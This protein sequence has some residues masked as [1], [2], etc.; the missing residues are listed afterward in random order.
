LTINFL[1]LVMIR[2][3]FVVWFL[4]I[5]VTILAD[6]LEET[7]AVLT[8]P[9]HLSSVVVGERLAAG[10]DSALSIGD[11]TN[12]MMGSSIIVNLKQ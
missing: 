5:Q 10:G 4:L 1:A 6:P 8:S 11:G 9:S 3:F 12:A 7:S 2:P